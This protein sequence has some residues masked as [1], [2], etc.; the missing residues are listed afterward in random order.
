MTMLNA[1]FRLPDRPELTIDEIR[2]IISEFH[3]TAHEFDELP[4]FDGK[5]GASERTIRI[6]LHISEMAELKET[7]EKGVGSEFL[8]A[9]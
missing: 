2:S 3:E 4:A 7:M 8:L 1:F 6:E 9:W 5:R